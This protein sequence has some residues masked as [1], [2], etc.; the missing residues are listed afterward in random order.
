MEDLAGRFLGRLAG[1]SGLVVG[2]GSLL[3][4]P[5]LLDEALPELDGLVFLFLVWSLICIMAT[6]SYEHTSH[7]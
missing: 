4:G 2:A 3:T 1:G 6:V 7:S 5:L